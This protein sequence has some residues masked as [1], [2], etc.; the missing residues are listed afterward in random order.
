MKKHLF[1]LFY[2]ISIIKIS[3]QSN[4]QLNAEI[5][6]PAMEQK[7]QQAKFKSVLSGAANTYDL[8]YHR[9]VWTVDPAVNYIKGAITSHFKPTI[10]GFN[11]MQFDLDLSF[12]IDSV[13]Y[14]T[15]TL[16]YA[17]TG[18]GILEITFP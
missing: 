11:L 8:K 15:T 12:T 2:I 6:I 9:C 4:S 14:H 5:D 16:T 1:L 7:A 18:T 10:A 3:A 17:Q 13:K